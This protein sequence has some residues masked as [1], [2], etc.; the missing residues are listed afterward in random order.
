[1]NDNLFIEVQLT[2]LHMFVVKWT[3]G[4]FHWNLKQNET[5]SLKNMSLNMSTK[6]H[7][8][9]AGLKVWKC[10]HLFQYVA[11]FT[12]QIA[13]VR[14]PMYS[15]VTGGYH[16]STLRDLVI[17]SRLCYFYF[18]LICDIG[19]LR[20]DPYLPYKCIWVTLSHL[21]QAVKETG[22]DK[23]DCTSFTEIVRKRGWPRGLFRYRLYRLT[24]MEIP[25]AE[26]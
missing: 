5:F 13:L 9:C 3:I 21:E 20:Q 22:W 6:W 16:D 18:I 17:I 19:L 2:T 25:T 4:K 24:S 14:K 26:T 15:F 8:F 10:T 23:R 11:I 12:L 7:S 1:M